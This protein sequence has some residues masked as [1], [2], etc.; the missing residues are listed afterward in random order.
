MIVIEQLYSVPDRLYR[1]LQ[2]IMDQNVKVNL[3]VAPEDLQELLEPR[4]EGHH[5]VEST[6]NDV[7][8]HG[9]LLSVEKIFTDP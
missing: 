4:E 5:L 3:L 7:L 2:S 8:D 1:V 6:L 9:L